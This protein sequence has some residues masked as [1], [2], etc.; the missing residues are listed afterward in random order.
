[1]PESLQI[2]WSM[3]SERR[4]SPGSWTRWTRDDSTIGRQSFEISFFF[5]FWKIRTFSH[6][7]SGVGLPSI[8]TSSF[9]G[10]STGN[11][12]LFRP[13]KNFGRAKCTKFW[14]FIFF[15][16]FVQAASMNTFCSAFPYWF[17]ATQVLPSGICFGE[18]EECDCAFGARMRWHPIDRSNINKHNI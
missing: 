7:T 4:S 15:G 18:A 6:L 2:G 16:E 3:S 5:I 8:L 12:L 9:I 14:T 13:C 10:L 11:S 1:M 17:S